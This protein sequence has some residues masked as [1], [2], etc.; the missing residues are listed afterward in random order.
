[1]H[2]TSVSLE[3]LIDSIM[4]A[5]TARTHPPNIIIK[6]IHRLFCNIAMLF[7]VTILVEITINNAMLASI[8]DIIPTM[9]LYVMKRPN[10]NPFPAPNAFLTPISLFYHEFF[11]WLHSVL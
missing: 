9:A 3:I 1:M 8:P 2:F 11:P 7:N 4:P 6:Y 10:T 5:N